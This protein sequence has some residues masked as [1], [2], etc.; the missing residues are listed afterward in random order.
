M[1][2]AGPCA[3]GGG[4]GALRAGGRGL[5]ALRRGRGV[6][7]SALRPLHDPAG[8]PAPTPAR[9]AK[10]CVQRKV[11]PESMWPCGCE[12]RPSPATAPG[13]T[14]D[15]RIV[16]L[17]HGAVESVCE[18][19]GSDEAFTWA[20]RGSQLGPAELPPAPR[21]ANQPGGPPLARG[22]R[23]PLARGTR[24]IAIP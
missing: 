10:S 11:L 21:K 4:R 23:P 14:S 6:A 22:T 24:W 19:Q 5:G 7:D 13:L 18:M 12:R 16:H 2:T 20:R 3:T 9:W 8:R 1:T 15:G 17:T